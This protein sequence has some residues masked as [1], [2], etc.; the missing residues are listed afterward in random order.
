[1]HR[2]ARD[3]RKADTKVLR[4]AALRISALGSRPG[5]HQI[6]ASISLVRPVARCKLLQHVFVERPSKI[7]RGA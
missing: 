6:P 1:M 4:S 7:G 5:L 2:P 3:G